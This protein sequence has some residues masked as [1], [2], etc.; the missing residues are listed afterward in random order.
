MDLL[1][2]YAGQDGGTGFTDSFDYFDRLS[3]NGPRINNTDCLDADSL[4]RV[5]PERGRMGSG[6]APF[7]I[8]KKSW[9]LVLFCRPPL[10]SFVFC[11]CCGRRFRHK[12]KSRTANKG[13]SRLGRQGGEEMRVL[14]SSSQIAFV[15]L[16]IVSENLPLSAKK[17]LSSH[18]RATDPP[19]LKPWRDRFHPIRKR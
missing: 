2:D 7:D 19:S 14:I 12:E 15:S 4:D 3:I 10:C 18:D 8:E 17:L 9:D 5:Y 1:R 16:F 6:Q 13:L 11:V